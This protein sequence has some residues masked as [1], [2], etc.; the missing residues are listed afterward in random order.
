MA[1]REIF[2][3][4]AFAAAALLGAAAISTLAGAAGFFYWMSL[5]EL[6]SDRSKGERTVVVALSNEKEVGDAMEGVCRTG[7]GL[8]AGKL[9]RAGKLVIVPGGTLISLREHGSLYKEFSM[10][11]FR[12]RSGAW[13]GH[14]G[15]TCPGSTALYHP[16]P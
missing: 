8:E 1:Q 4:L 12:F 5:G 11:S 14:D 10:T 6:V 16:Y 9:I 13:K 3:R 2:K 7:G 15:W